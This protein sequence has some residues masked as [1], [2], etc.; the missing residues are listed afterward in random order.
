MMQYLPGVFFD[1]IQPESSAQRLC[2][3]RSGFWAA[4]GT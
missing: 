2:A 4:D 1:D 3:I